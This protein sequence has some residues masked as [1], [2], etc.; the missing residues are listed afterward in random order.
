MVVLRRDKMRLALLLAPARLLLIFLVLSGTGAVAVLVDVLSF[1]LVRPLS[2]SAHRRVVTVVSYG[3]LLCGSFL[4]DRWTRIRLRFYG[5]RVA[6]AASSLVVVNHC[7]N[8]DW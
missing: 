7:S 1:V 4:I 3:F 2:L 8:V 6:P 5:T